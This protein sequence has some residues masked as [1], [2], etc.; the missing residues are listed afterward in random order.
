MKFE[1]NKSGYIKLVS[2]QD[3]SGQNIKHSIKFNQTLSQKQVSAFK[4]KE[5]EMYVKDFNIIKSYEKK[6]ELEAFIYKQREI[7]NNNNELKKYLKQE[8]MD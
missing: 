8:E 5:K 6:N 7:V 1:I 2:V 4:A 3:N